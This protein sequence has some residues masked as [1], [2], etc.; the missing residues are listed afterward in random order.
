MGITQ[1]NPEDVQEMGEDELLAAIHV[2]EAELEGR[3]L[4][5]RA[6]ERRALGDPREA[7]VLRDRARAVRAGEADPGWS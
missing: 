1:I 2:L 4:L 5:E 6:A 7:G 3:S